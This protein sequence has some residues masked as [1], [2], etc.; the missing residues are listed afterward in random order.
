MVR[1]LVSGGT[2]SLG[3]AVVSIL[4]N[5]ENRVRVLSRKSMASGTDSSV[6]WVQ[7][8]IATGIGLVEALAKVDV[9]VN[10]TGN[11][12]D[13]YE[14]D[15]LGVKRLAE[16][17]K[18]AGVKHFFHISIVGI[19]HIDL[20]YYR[21]KVSAEKA[22]IESGVPYSIQRV[23][24]FHTLLGFILSQMQS[25]PQGFE[26]PIAADAQ[27]QLIDTHDAA[28]YIFPLFLAE[29]SGKLPDVGGPEILRV[30]DIARIYLNQQGITNPIFTDAP[31][32]FFPP[33]AVEG[34]RHG[35]NTVPNNRYGSITWADYVRNK[36]L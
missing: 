4:K 33:A 30:E 20:N 25:S 23:T 31:K 19:E 21:Y 12:Q 10:F 9:V 17:A 3:S 1:I 14:T 27:F 22:I 34:F 15:V 7:G 29:P 35:F 36:F 2:G 18:Q 6:E 13:V 32:S 26:L 24:Q 11:A 5:T 16:M 28:Q 8:D